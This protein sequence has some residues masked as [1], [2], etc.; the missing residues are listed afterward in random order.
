MQ[1]AA[2]FVEALAPIEP[3]T[4]RDAFAISDLC[5]EFGVTPRALRF[6]EDEGLI[7]PE[8]RGTARI[9]SH[10]DRARLAWILRGKRVGFSLGEIREM[11]DLYDLGDGRQLQRQVTMQRCRERIALLEDQKKDIDAAI[12]ELEQFVTLIESRS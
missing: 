2:S 4:D 3:R 10:R 8:R 1:A 5:A 11:I 9:Y 6:Y 12:D 7:A